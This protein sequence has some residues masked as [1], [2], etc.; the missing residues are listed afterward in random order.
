MTQEDSMVEMEILC[1]WTDR[2][3][4]SDR[5]ERKKWST[6]EGRPFVPR[7]FRLI[8]AYYLHCNRNFY[9]N[10]S[11]LGIT[12]LAQLLH[13]RALHRVQLP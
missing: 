3:F 12:C 5:W 11:D 8:C 13:L 2:N 7:D 9:L 6:F 4:R 10:G 1:K